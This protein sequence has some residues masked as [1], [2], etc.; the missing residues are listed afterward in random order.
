MQQHS[1][2][3]NPQKAAIMGSGVLIISYNVGKKYR[4]YTRGEVFND[5]DGIM[6][7]IFVD[8]GGY[9]T[10]LQIGG[11]TL[12][13]EYKPSDNSYLRLEARSLTADNAQKIFYSDGKYS[14]KRGEIMLN[15]GVWFE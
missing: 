7:G 8:S 4:I 13:A 10:G 1:E 5:P 6:S 11:L 9:Y 12:G 2:I 15:L 14:N 3:A